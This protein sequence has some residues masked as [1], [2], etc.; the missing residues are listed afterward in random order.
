MKWKVI[1]PMAQALDVRPHIRDLV[2]NYSL[3]VA[4]EV[5][6]QVL[7]LSGLKFNKV[8]L[9]RLM[10][11]RIVLEARELKRPTK[12]EEDLSKMR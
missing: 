1:Q 7:V 11:E 12:V 4:H 3:V 6:A 5:G 8:F 2:T 9:Y 10:T